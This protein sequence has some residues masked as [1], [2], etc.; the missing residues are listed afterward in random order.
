MQKTSSSGSYEFFKSGSLYNYYTHAHFKSRYL[1]KTL[2][3]FFEKT[4]KARGLKLGYV[5]LMSFY[6]L[7]SVIFEKIFCSIFMAENG[8]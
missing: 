6:K 5:P 3:T 8:P 7:I 2:G 4:I 1:K